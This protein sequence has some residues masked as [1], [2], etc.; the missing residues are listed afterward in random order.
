[1]FAFP[2][3]DPAWFLREAKMYLRT[4]LLSWLSNRSIYRSH[5]K[6][7]SCLRTSSHPRPPP[8]FAVV[9]L[10]SAFF[11]PR[12]RSLFHPFTVVLPCPVTM[13]D[14]LCQDRAASAAHARFP[15]W[16]NDESGGMLNWCVSCPRGL[17]KVSR[18]GINRSSP[19]VR[20]R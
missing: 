16:R 2:R 9:P 18:A 12:S 20:V 14:W 13:I 15:D 10:H 7:M 8:S 1:M 3:E 4:L 5:G 11:F 17:R 6:H 19:G